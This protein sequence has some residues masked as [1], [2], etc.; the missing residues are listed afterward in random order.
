MEVV[1]LVASWSKD[2]STKVGA[3]IVGEAGQ[4]LSTGYNGLPRGVSD[5]PA[6]LARPEKYLWT[7]HAERNAIYNAARSGLS[8]VGSILYVG[9]FP[10]SDCARGV[11]QSGIGSVITANREIPDR[12]HGSFEVARIM[13]EEAGVL[14]RSLDSEAKDWYAGP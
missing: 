14:V 3:V 5:I 4:I 11:I 10:C 7:E 2:T 6:R 8:L 13:L 1:D 12:W 9:W